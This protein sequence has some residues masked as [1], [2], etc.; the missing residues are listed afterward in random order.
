MRDKE[1]E[2]Q[3][4]AAAKP[5]EFIRLFGYYLYILYLAEAIKWRT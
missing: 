4:V 3:K 1:R 5:D 2:R